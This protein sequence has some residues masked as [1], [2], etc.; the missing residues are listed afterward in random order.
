MKDLRSVVEAV[1]FMHEREEAITYMSDRKKVN[2][3]T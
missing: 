3:N 2:H 1:T